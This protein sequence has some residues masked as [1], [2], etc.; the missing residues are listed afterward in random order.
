M[1]KQQSFYALRDLGHAGLQ[2]R[3]T[4]SILESRNAG[5][6]MWPRGYMV[7]V[8]LGPGARCKDVRTS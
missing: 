6:E 8:D 4:D 5:Q 3:N 7:A 2:P 1:Q